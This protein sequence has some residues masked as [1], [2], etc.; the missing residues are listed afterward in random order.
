MATD[1]WQ[2]THGNRC[3]VCGTNTNKPHIPCVDLFSVVSGGL[4]T[5]LLVACQEVCPLRGY[6]PCPPP[7]PHVPVLMSNHTDS[8][9][10]IPPFSVLMYVSVFDYPWLLHVS[11]CVTLQA[12]T[13]FCGNGKGYSGDESIAESSEPCTNWNSS[14]AQHPNY[15][16]STNSSKFWVSP[17]GNQCRNPAGRG[18]Q[19]WCYTSKG[20]E[21]CTVPRCQEGKTSNACLFLTAV[22]FQNSSSWR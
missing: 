20:W 21:N 13:C 2:Q 19:P 17:V 22:K 18:S 15:S 4:G 3:V 16:L 14:S 7:L 8:F 12:D 1:T 5:F 6:S 10:W 11:V 9:L